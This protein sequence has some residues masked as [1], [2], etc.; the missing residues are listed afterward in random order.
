MHREPPRAKV[1]VNTTPLWQGLTGGLVLGAAA[2]TLAWGE[3]NVTIS[4]GFTNFGEVKHGPDIPHLPYV[5]PDAPKG[6]E[7]AIWSQ[8]NFDSFNNFTR[9]GVPAALSGLGQERLLV[10]TADDPYGIYCFLCETMEYPDSLDWVIFNLRND[11][12]FADG[13][14]MTAEDV[15]F[16]FEL[17]LEQGITEYRNVVEGFVD[18]VEV[19]DPYRIKF[20]FTEEAPRRDVISLAGGTNVFSKSWFE[21]TGAR[22][23]D[24]TLEP[25]MGT[26]PYMLQSTD[27]GRQ[28]VYGRN[29]NYWGADHPLQIGQ[30]NFDT[31][32]VEYFADSS[33]ALEAFKAGEYTFRIENSSK[34]WATAYDFPAI[35]NGDVIKTEL[36]DGSIGSGQSFVFNLRREKWQ[37]PKV[38]EAVRLMFNFEWSNETLFFGLYERV[39][40]FW[41]NSELEATGAPSEGEIALLQ[42]LVDDGL[43]DASILTEE[44]ILAPTSGTR[45]LDRRNLRAASELL[46]EAGWEVGADGVRTKNGERLTALI[47]QVSPAWDR[48]VNPYVENL[49]RLGVEAKL[50]RVDPSQY[51][52]RRRSGDYDLTNHTF[53]MSFEPGIG[54]RQWYDSSTADDSSRNLMGLEDPAIDRLVTHVIEAKSLEDMQTATRALDR[55]LR[56]TG[57]W[58]PQWFKDTHTIAYYNKFRHPDPIAPFSLGHLSYWWYDQEAADALKASGALD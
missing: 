47:L 46:D 19:L 26:G 11:V 31:I 20:T 15:K 38:R 32:R 56:K 12:V 4:H 5:N 17:F 48:I 41:E 6:G 40:S 36:P 30:N 35:D 27:I 33:A 21:E 23:D 14:P 2:A 51:I 37:D 13:R 45:S 53:S 58:V 24:S 43:I 44:A 50:E 16:T 28:I 18:S 34:D 25:F 57:F 22:L 55:A 7:I 42:P 39:N 49:S 54:L 3:E 1:I 9:K 10:G 29:P 8:G 52:D